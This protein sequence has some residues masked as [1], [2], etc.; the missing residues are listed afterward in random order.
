M[1]FL[2]TQ[3]FSKKIIIESL[4]ISTLLSAFIYLAH[5]NIELKIVDSII[6][7]LGVFLLL[8][9]SRAVMFFSGFFIGIFWFWWFAISLQ[10]YDLSYLAP[11][12]IFGL[13]ISYG[14]SFLALGVFKNLYLK[15]ILIFLYLFFAPFGFDW[16]KL[17]LVF[18]NSYF[19]SSYLA[20][21]LILIACLIVLK[22]SLKNLRVVAILPL[23][24]ALNIFEK[25]HIVEDSNVK[26]YLSQFNISQ[27]LRWQKE[28][29]AQ[30]NKKIFEKIDYAIENN[31]D[32]VVLPET[33][34]TLVLNENYILMDRLLNLS[35]KIDIIAGSVYKD[36]F[37]YFNASYFFSKNQFEVAKKVVLVPF[38]EEIPL[39]KF[40]VD[41]I[42]DLFYGGASDYS[43]ADKPTDFL[44]KDSLFRN[45]ICY[46]GTNKKIFEN[47]NGVK[48]MIMISNNAWFTP[49]HEPT[50]QALLLKYY[51]KKYGLTI[52]HVANGSKNMVIK[53]N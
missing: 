15:A 31:Y 32:V 49:S 53:P 33:I 22:S 2:K 5:F 39:P 34:F 12:I 14:L 7:V 4:I 45:A 9:A 26:I 1:F 35:N 8:K 48:N 21:A 52:Y 40:F 43:K 42:N 47:L 24:F 19:S 10:Y 27:D 28:N 18:I 41:L 36:E 29:F 50:L 46:E 37:G 51:A 23:I 6:A 16:L 25:E 11:I 44:I 30:I 38:G 13:A 3:Y 17:N 20:F